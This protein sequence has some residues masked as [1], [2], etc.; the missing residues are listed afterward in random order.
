M[1]CS[2][3]FGL[4]PFFAGQTYQFDI[5][6]FTEPDGTPLDFTG[7]SYVLTFKRNL[8]L[9]DVQ[10]TGANGFQVRVVATADDNTAR[11]VSFR[12][13][14]AMTAPLSGD[15]YADVIEITPGLTPIVTPVI[16]LQVVRVTVSATRAI[17]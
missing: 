16:P 7:R 13:D 8:D 9:S 2:E 14:A 4:R 12:V 17:A 15:Y 6:D 1:S 10:A 3:S 5:T 11:K